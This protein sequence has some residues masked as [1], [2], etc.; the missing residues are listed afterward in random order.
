MPGLLRRGEQAAQGH[1]RPKERKRGRTGPAWLERDGDR[2][3]APLGDQVGSL[4]ALLL[5]LSLS[6]SLSEWRGLGKW[7][8]RVA[9]A[10]GP[11]STWPAGARGMA[12]GQPVGRLTHTSA[13]QT[14]HT[15]ANGDPQVT[16]ERGYRS[17]GAGQGEPAEPAVFFWL[18]LDR[19]MAY[20][21]AIG[22]QRRRQRPTEAA[23]AAQLASV[24]ISVSVS[25]FWRCSSGR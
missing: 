15:H 18:G 19:T 22:G 13:D 10:T 4:C 14:T 6:V 2:Y 20:R 12:R 8:I 11:R 23:K 1:R 5:S 24:S 16:C 3:A 17:E 21:S 7:E 25:A 9:M